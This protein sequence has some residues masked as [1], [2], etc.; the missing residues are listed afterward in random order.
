MYKK[1]TSTC[2]LMG[3]TALLSAIVAPAFAEMMPPEKSL[4]GLEY[5]LIGK[6]DIFDYAALDSYSEAPF[7]T[8][9]V[10]AGKL[11]AVA[12]RL[13][14]EPIVM[15][16]GAMSDGI[17][18]YGGVFRHVIGGRPE[19][20]NWM[21]GQHQGWGGINMAMQ[22][23]LV[24]QGPRWQVK[25]EEQ[26]GPLPNLAQ[27]WEWNA[28]RTEVTMHLM[29]GV[30][31]SDG[32]AFDVEDVRFW[33]ED[34]VQNESVASRMPADSF[35]G[36]GTTM[37]VID[38]YTFK[39]TFASPQSEN[40]LE[41]L[42]YIQGC[43][44]PSH[45]LKSNHPSY[46]SDATYESYTG[47]MPNDVT[48]AVVLG[49][50]VP[51]VHRPDELVIMRRNPY[52]FKV[53]ESGQQLPYY[54]EMHFKLST[55]G[56]RT[57]QAVAGTGDFS[58]MED[59][60]NFVEALKQSQDADS[61]VVANFGPRVLSWRLMLNFD[62][63]SAPDDYEKALRGVF[64]EK[65][66]RVALSHA[67]DRNAIGQSVARGPFAY[68][69]V[70]GF[71]TGSPYYD[72][73]SSVF[74]AYDQSKAATLLDGLGL[75]DSDGDGIRNLPNGGDNIIIDVL[76]EAERNADSKQLEAVASQLE[77][78]GIRL[79]AR[80]S[81][82]TTLDTNRTGGT[83]T[84]MLSRLPVILPTRETC[85]SFPAGTNCPNFNK[86][87]D[88]LDFEA[89]LETAF[90]A[91]NASNDAAERAQLAKDMQKLMTENVY[92]IGTVQ[93]PAA[94]LVNK[95]VRNAHPG[96]PVFMYE[97]AEDSVMRERLWTPASLQVGEIL[98]GTVAEY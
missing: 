54:N 42:A 9:F 89:E 80:S 88:R 85:E 69:Y 13:P 48:P 7:L 86:G 8:E 41:G 97:W 10:A 74:Q 49:A 50:W 75:A 92:Y 76:V 83:Y 17:G 94:L 25:A 22:E 23:C 19:G 53:D 6:A 55:W 36:A 51:T 52:Y 1:L 35:G 31:W 82:G 47:S 67:L 68:P 4:S 30:K 78:V 73:D 59:P 34:N 40:V 63:A 38:D 70:A 28:D 57:A 87:G 56:D 77:E 16:T 29:E 65:D 11:P 37:E 5:E 61:P 21:A 62:V 33:W 27:S 60:G 90:N 84:A 98:P 45:I 81:D 46:N 44:G 14:S 26:T 91:F 93:V 39:F 18:E 72:A 32:D 58:N 95:R 3:A 79:Q 2:G 71:A 24:R 66:F 20:W 96:T 12:D 15:K 64:R 43:P